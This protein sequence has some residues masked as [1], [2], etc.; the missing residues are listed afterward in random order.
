MTQ[1][2]FEEFQELVE[3]FEPEMSLKTI[4]EQEGVPY[5]A[6]ISWRN[7]HGIS[8]SRKKR[9]APRG[10]IEVEIDETPRPKATSK[11]TVQMEFENGIRFCRE[12]MEVESLIEFLTQIRPVLCLS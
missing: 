3:Q 12:G 5:R 6:Y 1:Y 11:V 10:M 4:C 7:N 9:S 2:N 8:K